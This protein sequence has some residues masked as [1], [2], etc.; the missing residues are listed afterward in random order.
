MVLGGPIVYAVHSG[1]G[2]PGSGSFKQPEHYNVFFIDWLTQC[3]LPA[4]NGSLRVICRDPNLGN[5]H[6]GCSLVYF[7]EKNDILGSWNQLTLMDGAVIGVAA[8]QLT[9]VR[10]E[11]QFPAGRIPALL[12]IEGRGELQDTR[13]ARHSGFRDFIEDNLEGTV[14]FDDACRVGFHV[15]RNLFWSGLLEFAIV[16]GIEDKKTGRNQAGVR[17]ESDEFDA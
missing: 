6:F 12:A 4:N 14:P 10:N 1:N 16:A 7:E 5:F 11:G 17:D 2:F 15:L 9:L 13:R 3:D 8:F